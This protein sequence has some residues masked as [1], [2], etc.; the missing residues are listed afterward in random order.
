MSEM[1][2][3]LISPGFGAGWTSWASGSKEFKT[4]MLTYQPII[5]ALESGQR[6]S[7]VH[8]A[9]LQFLDDAKSKF[10]ETPYVGGADDLEVVEA[11]GPVRI[12]EY[13]GSESL[14]EVG[15]YQEWL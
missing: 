10:N 6:I 12:N 8:P 9:V 7:E 3:V 14:E 5:D 1:G 13:D 2:K 11:S 15:D 4:F